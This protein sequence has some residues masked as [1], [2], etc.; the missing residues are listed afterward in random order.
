MLVGALLYLLE[1]VAI[2]ATGSVDAGQLTAVLGRSGADTIASYQGREDALAFLAAWFSVVLLGRIL[3]IIGLK[4]SLA[5]S[6]RPNALMDFAVAAMTVSVVIEIAGYGL[7]A[8]A[9]Q[10]GAEHPEGV[11][12]VEWSAGALV[13]LIAGAVGASVLC[14]AWVMLRSGIFPIA[15]SILGIAAGVG[16]ILLNL[17]TDPAFDA[18]SNVLGFAPFVFW[19]WMLWT[20][21]L[22]WIRTPKHQAAPDDG[23]V[24]A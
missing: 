12:A 17:L 1:W 7:V 23:S 3:L 14:S 4:A 10:L 9:A 19:L 21:V 2:I 5:A 13:G 24:T 16:L 18:L 20:G 8:A 22:L 11:V 6:G 15:L